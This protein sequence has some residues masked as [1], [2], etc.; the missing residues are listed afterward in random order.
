MKKLLIASILALGMASTANAAIEIDENEGF[1]PT[2]GSTVADLTVG[3]PLQFIGAVAGTALH[4]VSIPFSIASNSVTESYDTLVRQPWTALQRCNGCTPAYD[5][6]IKTQAEG[7]GE[8]RI[9]VDRPSEVVIQT[10]NGVVVNGVVA[11]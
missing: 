5:N 9:V 4:V 1:G 7:T 8:V 3:K 10:Q 2:Y 6:Y 11:Q